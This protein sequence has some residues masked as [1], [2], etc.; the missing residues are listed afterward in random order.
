M[1]TKIAWV[2]N[3]DGTPGETIN[4]GV[5]CD[6][7]ISVDGKPPRCKAKCY[8]ERL[9][10]TRLAHL[11][12]YKGLTKDGRWTGEVRYLPGVMDR[13]LRRKKPTTYFAGDM[14]EIA[15][16]G[17][18]TIEMILGRCHCAPR[19]RFIF[20]SKNLARWEEF[21]SRFPGP[22][23]SNCVLLASCCD[24]ED[25][26]ERVPVLLRLPF[27]TR[28][29]SMEPLIGPVDLSGTGA[30]GL[31]LIIFGGESGTK[32]HNTTARACHQ[33]WIR[34]GVH[35]CAAAK[36]C[37]FVKQMGSR[38]LFPPYLDRFVFSD[39]AGGDPSEWPEDLRVRQL[40]WVRP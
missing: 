14:T 10:S 17:F 37:C 3:H 5:G 20:V 1:P 13:V 26:D 23:P 21:F 18:S 15:S 36:V 32:G 35:Q 12:A 2:I 34:S 16:L 30:L 39:R 29:L 27:K 40:P 25:V 6:G 28:G 33:D 31:D 8:A 38:S 11:P 7:R 22:A 9:A 4:P 24:K 19:H